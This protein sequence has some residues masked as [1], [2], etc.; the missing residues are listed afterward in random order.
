MYQHH[1]VNNFKAVLVTVLPEKNAP[2]GQCVLIHVFYMYIFFMFGGA[3][4][5]SCPSKVV[6]G[7]VDSR[8]ILS[9]K[10]CPKVGVALFPLINN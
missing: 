6:S 5:H 4:R 9:W 10:M 8:N 1:L 3:P 2:C 7:V